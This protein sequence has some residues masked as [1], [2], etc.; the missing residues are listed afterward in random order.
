MIVLIF[1]RQLNSTTSDTVRSTSN[2]IREFIN[3]SNATNVIEP[4]SIIYQLKKVKKATLKQIVPDY[5]RL[6][7]FY[8]LL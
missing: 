5:N 8:T 1:A 6:K 2:A 7:N 4:P 3:V